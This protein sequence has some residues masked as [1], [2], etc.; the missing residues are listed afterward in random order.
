M[1]FETKL[2]RILAIE[3]TKLK[4]LKLTNLMFQLVPQSPQQIKVKEILKTIPL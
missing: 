1:K 3:N 4:Q 2:N